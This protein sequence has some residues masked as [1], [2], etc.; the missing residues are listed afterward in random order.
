MR[1]GLCGTSLLMAATACDPRSAVPPDAY[2]TVT[3]PNPVAG[4]AVV[5]AL[6]SDS[7]ASFG[8][9]A[10]KY[11]RL[12]PA[13]ILERISDDTFLAVG[14]GSV[15]ITIPSEIRPISLSFTVE[16]PSVAETVVTHTNER[17][18][19][20]VVWSAS[21]A[22]VHR[23]DGDLHVTTGS[24]TIGPC[25]SVELGAGASLIVG[26]DTPPNAVALLKIRGSRERPIE[27]NGIDDGV[28]GRVAWG[29]IR[30]NVHRSRGSEIRWLKVRGAVGQSR[31]G[32]PPAVVELT[33]ESHPYATPPV[34]LSSLD[35]ELDNC[36]RVG[37]RLR[38][39][40]IV[41]AH[42]WSDNRISGCAQYPVEVD[43]ISLGAVPR[44]SYGETAGSEARV[45]GGWA[46]PNHQVWDNVGIPYRV[47]SS[48]V[49]G[50][51]LSPSAPIAGSEL[52][53]GGHYVAVQ[54]GA[55]FRF[56]AGT[57]L[58]VGG[59]P[60][61][62]LT[63][64]LPVRM[65]VLGVLD[66]PVRF[67]SAAPAPARGDWIGLVFMENARLTGIGPSADRLIGE[68]FFTVL[69]G[70]VVEYAGGAG[71]GL[72]DPQG[73]E[74]R[75]GIIVNAPVT[76]TGL[77][78]VW[79][80]TGAVIRHNGGYGISSP[81]TDIRLLDY[82]K[83]KAFHGTVAS[84]LCDNELGPYSPPDNRLGTESPPDEACPCPPILPWPD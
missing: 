69:A 25:V 7:G 60:G 64:A 42:G 67:T 77:T 76:F 46:G 83:P 68:P 31:L 47:E 10:L 55:T 63:S 78:V 73:V 39:V 9:D 66:Q 45:T 12:V 15:T 79:F 80:L 52:D 58:F 4:D 27:L 13:G 65:T 3:P 70:A 30:V 37:I 11:A 14:S 35:I 71:S 17:I 21:E 84:C 44:G 18:T 82:T 51:W 56:A 2:L 28:G 36:P 6:R 1:L 22:R 16:C 23:I 24:L 72:Y 20:D 26:E 74:R 57:G 61:A 53:V 50:P 48:I 41:D 19:T 43:A 29:G 38:E 54:A 33:G 49:V 34:E 75:G 8:P 32:D 62:D 5:A 59:P 40:S 81:I